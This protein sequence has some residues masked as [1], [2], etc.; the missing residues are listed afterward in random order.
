[1]LMAI[2]NHIWIV[3]TAA[4][5]GAAT[6]AIVR[7][8]IPDGNGVI[9]GCYRDDDG[10]L[11]VVDDPKSC[12][13]NETALS[14]SQTGDCRLIYSLIC[15]PLEPFNESM[16]IAEHPQVTYLFAVERKKGRTVPPDMA[17]GWLISEQLGSMVPMIA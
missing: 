5:V 13:R 3:L 10:N 11:R 6:F 15:R 12:R 4:V 2:K 7:A 14:W 9:H 1:M 8:A 16:N 17:P